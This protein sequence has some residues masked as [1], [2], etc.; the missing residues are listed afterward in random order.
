M[1]RSRG[2]VLKHDARTAG[3]IMRLELQMGGL[4]RTKFDSI[5]KIKEKG[6][7]HRDEFSGYL[8][9]CSGRICR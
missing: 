3:T 6:V 2:E 7:E 1:E 8:S 9:H 5:Q 4:E